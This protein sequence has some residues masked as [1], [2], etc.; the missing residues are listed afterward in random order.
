MSTFWLGLKLKHL[1]HQSLIVSGWQTR[2]RVRRFPPVRPAVEI[3][4]GQ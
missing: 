2:C 3:S 1:M 4:P